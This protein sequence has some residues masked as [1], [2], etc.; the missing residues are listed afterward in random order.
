MNPSGSPGRWEDSGK[1][2]GLAEPHHSDT[3]RGGAASGFPT[4]FSRVSRQASE[5]RSGGPFPRGQARG[6]H[7]ARGVC[8]CSSPVADGF[9]DSPVLHTGGG[10]V[11]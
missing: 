4:A 10:P 2:H 1:T 5:V 11:P 9:G 7:S 8:F 3:R 6:C